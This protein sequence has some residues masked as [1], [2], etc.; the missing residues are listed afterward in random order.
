MPKG[1]SVIV[2]LVVIGAATGL[3]LCPAYALE[4]PILGTALILLV[5]GVALLFCFRELSKLTETS[6]GE[7]AHAGEPP[8]NE[9]RGPS[10]GPGTEQGVGESTLDRGAFRRARCTRESPRDAMIEDA[11]DPPAHERG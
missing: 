9:R 7:R 4:T 1:V 3:V 6:S 11:R 2:R 10:T 8:R 5:V